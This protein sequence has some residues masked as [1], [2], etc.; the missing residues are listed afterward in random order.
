VYDQ[1]AKSLYVYA[2]RILRDKNEAEDA[3]QLTFVKFFKAI[4][5]YRGDS[6]L[7]TYLMKIMINVCNDQL[8]K[9]LQVQKI[10]MDEYPELYDTSQSNFHELLKIEECI[11]QLPVGMRQCFVLHHIEGFKINE[12]AGMTNISSGTVKSHLFKA[13]EK[14]QRMLS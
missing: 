5:R 1:Y 10:S 11:K 14:L 7:Y 6:N 2:V 3:L 4:K 9:M 12:I 8:K 13:R